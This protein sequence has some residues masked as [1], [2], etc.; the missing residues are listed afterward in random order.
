MFLNL[1]LFSFSF[2]FPTFIFGQENFVFENFSI[3]QGLS[4]PTINCIY[5]DKYGFLWL[6]TNDGLS[7]YDGYEFKVYKNN[8]SDSASLSGNSI[9]TITEDNNGNLWIGG[10]N[11]L[12][13]Y[14]R[15]NNKFKRVKFDREQNLNQPYVTKIFI[16]KKNRIWIGTAFYGVHLLDPLR[17]TTKRIKFILNNKEIIKSPLFSIIE[18]SDREILALDYTE[19]IFYYNEVDH[20]FQLFNNLGKNE[21]GANLFVLYQDEFDRLWIGGEESLIIYNRNTKKLEKVELFSKL[22]GAFPGK[23][24]IDNIKDQVELSYSQRTSFLTKGIINILKDKAGFLWLATLDDG[25]YRYNPVENIF[26]HFTKISNNKNSIK[27]A[28][29]LSLFQDSFGNVWIGTRDAGLY[30][31][32]PNKQPMNV[33]KIP[34]ELKTNSTADR[35][36]AVAKGKKG[37]NIAIG[38]AG[39]GVLWQNIQSG[40]YKNYRFGQNSNSVSSNNIFALTMDAENNIWI[41]SNAGL[42]KLNPISGKVT[43]YFE[44]HISLYRGFFIND[45]KFDKTGRLFIVHVG[46]VEILYPNQNIV[47]KIPSLSNRELKPKLQSDII[48]LVNSVQPIASILKAGE[49]ELLENEFEVSDSIKIL[50]IG[51]GEGQTNLENMYDFGWLEDADK[52]IIWGMQKFW[53]SFHFQ[54]GFKNRIMVQTLQLKKGIYKLK[55]QSDEGHSYGNF[56][57][58]APKDSALWGI[59]IIRISDKQFRDFSKRID[60]AEKNSSKMLLE[61][62]N[63]IFISKFY[64]NILWIGTVNQGLFKYNLSNGE[65]TQYNK[66]VAAVSDFVDNNEVYFILEDSRGIIWFSSP[67]G[68]G[69]L[70]PKTGEIK[71]FTEKDGLPTNLISAIQEDNFGNLWISSAAGL[72]TMVRNSESKKESFINI[73]I[74]DGLQGYSYSK[75]TWKTDNGELFF[76]GDNGLN[77]FIPGRTNQ[78]KPKIVITD[79]RISDVSVFN[80]I[81]NYPLKNDLNNTD[82]LTLDYSQNNIAFQFA[83]IH[84]SRPERNLIAYKLDG[85]NKD[86]VYSKLHF[87]SFT[88]LEPGEYTFKLKAANGDGVWSDEEKSIHI[89]VLPPWWRTTFAY[90]LYFVLFA[91]LIF[92]IDRLQSRRLLHKAKEKMKIQDAE[93]RAETAELQAKATEAQSKVIQAENERKSKELEEARQLQLSMLPKELPQ[94]PNLDIAVYMQTATEVGGDY[95]D[96]HVGLDGTLTVVIGDATGHGMKA[97]TMVT[98]A[99]SLFNSYAPNPDILFSFHEF[100]RCI[101]KMNFDNLSMCLTM[102]KIKGDKMQIS[103]AGMPPSFI[104]RGDTKVVEEHLF[105]AMPLGTM[106]KFPYELKDAML[107][108]GDTI[109]LMSDG[110]PELTNDK[111]EMYGYKRIRNGFEDVA[112]KSPEEIISFLKNEA[113]VWNN[114]QPPDDDVTFVVIEMKG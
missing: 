110:L 52:N 87:A 78:T 12:A 55:Y 11:V 86:W 71:F 8:P 27:S 64:E 6:G 85:F 22:R 74:K 32:D 101:K 83:P 66:N 114:D 37:A 19:G 98:T 53:T 40:N 96:F 73:D 99:K 50:I 10:Y 68:L 18:T 33:F 43:K 45:L 107:K 3:P 104:F 15:K 100:T 28:G 54:G 39:L 112:E 93:H 88:N 36:T 47:K 13:K 70:D 57:V 72:T 26:F 1:L 42:D 65:F 97:G 38:T 16:D 113:S 91:G 9:N 95:Y 41:G 81:A 23:E 94:L 108:P 103:T 30:K 31:V 63:S 7:R 89:E 44:N 61:V 62:T 4:N 106:E 34:E 105:Q 109:L 2:I 25:L 14:D 58:L 59:Q 29:I 92:V 77:Y 67:N 48:K 5:E 24:T 111:E 51:V 60:E 49:K 79:F 82:E 84:Y 90:I 76:A 35:I 20:E 21:V 46:G 56:N 80:D 102:L 17:M 75:A 69:K